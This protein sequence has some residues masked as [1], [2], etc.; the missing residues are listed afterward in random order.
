[1]LKDPAKHN[2]IQVLNAKLKNLHKKEEKRLTIKKS[3]GLPKIKRVNKTEQLVE[4]K[5]GIQLNEKYDKLSRMILFS[6]AGK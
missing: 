6:K 4:E 2:E 5:V 3:E 1:M